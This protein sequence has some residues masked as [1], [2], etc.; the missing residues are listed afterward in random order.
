MR[1]KPGEPAE[2]VGIDE[3][4]S[5]DT[6]VDPPGPRPPEGL[7]TDADEVGPVLCRPAPEAR[8]PLGAAQQ[9]QPDSVESKPPLMA[10]IRPPAQGR[11]R[12]VER[13][14]QPSNLPPP[15]YIGVIAVAPQQARPESSEPAQH[16]LGE[17][18][19]PVIVIQ[20]NRPRPGTI[21]GRGGGRRG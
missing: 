12:V 5:A 19:V 18:A 8:P 16:Q 14:Q 13:A 15:D 20:V 9:H 17:Q 4:V 10:G 3:D 7:G 6:R 21:P 2:Q 1:W 11:P